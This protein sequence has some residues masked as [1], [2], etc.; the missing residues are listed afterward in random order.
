[1][2]HPNVWPPS[3]SLER[4]GEVVDLGDR[5]LPSITDLDIWL[6]Y[7]GDVGHF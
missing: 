4:R 5:S 3:G 7:L 2:I 6:A 1:M